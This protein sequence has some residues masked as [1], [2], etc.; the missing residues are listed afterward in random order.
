[1]S[2][3]CD[4]QIIVLRYNDDSQINGYDGATHDIDKTRV[5][6]ISHTTTLIAFH[7]VLAKHIF[8]LSTKI[9]DNNPGTDVDQLWA[10]QNRKEARSPSWEPLPGSRSWEPVP[11][12]KAINGYCVYLTL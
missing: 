1:M 3:E 9:G 6:L 4:S 5:R 12:I 11:G 7:S 10:G 2:D 8:L